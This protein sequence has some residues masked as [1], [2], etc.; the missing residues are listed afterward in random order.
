MRTPPDTKKWGPPKQSLS[1]RRSSRAATLVSQATRRLRRC[2]RQGGWPRRRWRAGSRSART[3]TACVRSRWRAAR[4]A[5]GRCSARCRARSSSTAGTPDALPTVDPAVVEVPELRALDLRVPL[6]ELVA[7]EKTRSFARAFSSS[8]RPPPNSAS[9]WCFSTVSSSVVVCSWL[10]LAYLPFCSTT[11]PAS[12]GEP[13]HDQ[14]VLAAGEQQHRPFEL[15]GDLAEDVDGLGL[16]HLELGEPVVVVPD[17]MR[18]PC[19]HCRPFARTAPACASRERGG[20]TR[21][22]APRARWSVD[23]RC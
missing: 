3:P 8:R 17:V 9:N 14:R 4:P 15:R 7:E 2:R 16:Q 6:A 18:V 13:Q 11:R 10:R 12:L 1:E 23:E 21:S 22:S 20:A 5:P 19:L